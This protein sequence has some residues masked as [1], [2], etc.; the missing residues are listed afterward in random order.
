M[1]PSI[2]WVHVEAESEVSESD[3][4]DLDLLK[5]FSK[6]N[7][8]TS[9]DYVIINRPETKVVAPSSTFSLA[10]PTTDIRRDSQS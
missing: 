6:L 10:H 3:H 2:F 5:L 8:V 7:T 9:L 1:F 4:Y